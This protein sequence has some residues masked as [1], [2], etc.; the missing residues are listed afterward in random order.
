VVKKAIASEFEKHSP[1]AVKLKILTASDK[2]I[3]K[4]GNLNSALS[5]D[6]LN[7]I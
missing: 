7:K 2:E 5:L 6:I 4:T 1:I 3:L